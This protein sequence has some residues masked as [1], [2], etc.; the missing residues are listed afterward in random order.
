MPTT[1]IYL[2]TGMVAGT[3]LSSTYEG[4]HVTFEESVITHPSHTDGFVDG[5]DPVVIDEEVGVAFTG[6][7]AV[8]DLIAIDTEGI[9]WLNVVATDDLGNSAVGRGDRIYI[10]RTTC[11]LS[12]ISTPASQL[13]F[14]IAQGILATGTTG[15]VGVKV[16]QDPNSPQ[17]D[18]TY[19]VVSK[20]GND[21]YGTGTW[22]NPLLTVQ[23]ALDLVTATRKT[24]YVLGGTYDE[25]ITWPTTT[26]VILK[27][28]NRE[29]GVVL[30]DSTE[31]DAVINVTPGVQTETFELTLENLYIDHGNAGQD[32]IS[33]DNTDMA[34]K[35]NVYIRDCGGDADSAADRFIVTVQ[36]DTSNAIRIYLYGDNGGV[37]GTIYMIAGND[38]NRFYATSAVLN[39][40]LSTSAGAIAFDIRFINCTIL[41]EGV[42]GGNGAQTISACGC[43]S[44]TGAT[45]AALDTD[46]LAGSHTETVIVP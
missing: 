15:V 17:I 37:E 34:K 31:Q 12:K 18:V 29:W 42:T 8:T 24:I 23:A 19:L 14:G 36:G 45:F 26:G 16:H 10:N 35:L 5:G 38:G 46:D 3:E 43:F 28:M 25:A 6:A 9:W 13:F 40:G 32:G 4:R 27:G 20:S 30:T 41:H 7:S 22:S 39:G 1:D 33:L 11:V 2:A 44:L 21:T